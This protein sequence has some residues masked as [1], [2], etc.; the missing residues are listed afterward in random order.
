MTGIEN[1]RQNVTTTSLSPL[2]LLRR[3][4]AAEHIQQKWGY[5]CSPRTLAKYA[6][7]GGGPPFRKAG[8]I[9]PDKLEFRDLTSDGLLQRLLTVLV[10]PSQRGDAYHP[11]DGAE[12]DYEKLIRS[13]SDGPLKYYQFSK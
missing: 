9:Q 10:A 2:R 7:I 6:V 13:I 3:A 5:P 1:A 4:E 12:E 11:V 8:G